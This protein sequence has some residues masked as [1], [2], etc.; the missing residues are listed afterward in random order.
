MNYTFEAFPASYGVRYLDS[1]RGKIMKLANTAKRRGIFRGRRIPMMSEAGMLP[2][3]EKDIY[4]WK[5]VAD[6]ASG[7][8]SP[9]R[10][11][12]PPAL[13]RSK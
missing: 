5:T 13:I 7:V 3:H 9:R 10:A 2:I 11:I 8:A 1:T 6:N 4:L 12:R